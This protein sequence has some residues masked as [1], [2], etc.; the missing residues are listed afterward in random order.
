MGKVIA[1]PHTEESIQAVRRFA[2]SLAFEMNQ[3]K[4]DWNYTKAALEKFLDE[5]L[6]CICCNV[7]TKGIDQLVKGAKV[8]KAVEQVVRFI[9]GNGHRSSI[10]FIIEMI[11]QLP[12]EKRADYE[13]EY[14]VEKVRP[15]IR[16]CVAL[17][18]SPEDFGEKV[19]VI[20]AN[21]LLDGE[22]VEALLKRKQSVHF[23]ILV[24]KTQKYLINTVLSRRLVSE[25]E[26]AKDLVQTIWL[27]L[28]EK[29]E[30]FHYLSRFN[31]WA[32]SILF[33]EYQN[34]RRFANAEKRGGGIRPISLDAPI[35]S[36]TPKQVQ[37]EKIQS[38]DLNPEQELLHHEI[39]TLLS[40]H[41]DK[42][43]KDREKIVARLGL[44]ELMTPKE[45]AEQLNMSSQNV[46][47]IIF[48]IRKLLKNH[49]DFEK[50]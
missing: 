40:E 43:K 38:E 13:T 48:R 50:N 17:N 34:Q 39:I 49:P 21:Y 4:P 19:K 7:K 25:M 8:D 6:F 28:L 27:K 12:F 33:Q 42:L 24:R 30:G 46:S 36:D 1:I 44:L 2:L 16:S 20:I 23:D 9:L 45:V 3:N 14:L 15:H 35:S 47:K 32:V 18:R 41:I 5:L 37:Y 11:E 10:D 29:L 26:Q 31:V 22:Q